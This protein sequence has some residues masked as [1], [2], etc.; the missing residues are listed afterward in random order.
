M[1]VREDNPLRTPSIFPSQTSGNTLF[2]CI[3]TMVL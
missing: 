1:G 3:I 2:L